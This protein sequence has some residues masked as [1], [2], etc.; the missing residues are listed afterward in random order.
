MFIPNAGKHKLEKF[1]I[2]KPGIAKASQYLQFSEIFHIWLIWQFYKAA[3]DLSATFLKT[4][5]IIA[6]FCFT[7]NNLLKNKI[8]FSKVMV[9]VLPI[10]K[11]NLLKSDFHLPKKFVLFASSKAL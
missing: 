6:C 8:Y 9:L 7:C 10:A 11:S 2:K 1:R 4:L 5:A 3:V